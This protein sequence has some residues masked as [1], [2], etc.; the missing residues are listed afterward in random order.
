MDKEKQEDVDE[1]VEEL[2][3]KGEDDFLAGLTFY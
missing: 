2:K 1:W 3:E